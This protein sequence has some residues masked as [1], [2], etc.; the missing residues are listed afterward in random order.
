MKPTS[1]QPR[2]DDR[3]RR[4]TH[5][6]ALARIDAQTYKNIDH[7]SKLPPPV[8]QARLRALDR[9][10]DVE[11]FLETNASALALGG[12]V[13]GATKDRRWLALS[14]AVLGFLFLH[15]TQGWCPPLPVLRAR[16]VRTRG[17]IDQEKAVL[18]SRL[19]CA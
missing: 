12:I 10:W 5:P 18:Q 4:H 11:R 6:A 19:C 2:E 8:I 1:F 17:E 15:A 9:E 13:L 3:V 14:A 16:G 7:F